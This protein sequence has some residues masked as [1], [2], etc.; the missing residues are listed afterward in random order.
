MTSTSSLRPTYILSAQLAATLRLYARM[1]N[2]RDEEG[3]K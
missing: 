2:V 3:V 1:S